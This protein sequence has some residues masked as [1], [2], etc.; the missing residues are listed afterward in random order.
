M[1]F[2]RSAVLRQIRALAYKNVLVTVIRRPAGFLFSTY[3]FPI[4]I[5]WFLIALPSLLSSSV[6]NGVSSPAAVKS[7]AE[8]VQNRLIIVQPDDLGPDVSRVI[9]TFT[10]SIPR[11]KVV[12]TSTESDLES[13]CATDLTGR[14]E[15]HGAVIFVDSPL[16][17]NKE[18]DGSSGKAWKYTIRAD[19]AL[20]DRSFDATSHHGAQEDV[21]LPLQVAIDRAITN[22]TSQPEVFRFTEETQAEATKADLQNRVESVSQVYAFALF[23]AYYLTIYRLT[24]FVT[25]ERES[26]MSQLLDAMGGPMSPISRVLSWLLVVD[27]LSIPCFIILGAIYSHMLFPTSSIGVVILWQVLLGLAVNSSTVFAASFFSSSRTSAIYVMGVFLLLSIITNSYANNLD[28]KPQFGGALFLS[29]FFPSSGH[30]F[31][32]QQLSFWELLGTAVDLNSLPP[33]D[34]G[35]GLEYG[36]NPSMLLGFLGLQIIVYPCATILVEILMHGIS[37]RKRTFPTEVASGPQHPFE[38]TDLHKKFYPGLMKRIFCCGRKGVVKALDG[39]S[40]QGKQG[41]ITCLLGPNGSGKT[42][43]LHMLSGFLTPSSGSINLGVQ[44]SQMGVCPQRD[45]FWEQLSVMEHIKIWS[46][47]KSAR[48]LPSKELDDLAE[49]CDLGWKR[50][51]KASTLSG[52]QKRKLQLACMF[53]GDSRLCLIDECTSGLDPLS[54]QAVWKILLQQRSRRTIVLTTHF[55]DEV[56]ILADDIVIMSK[57]KIKCQGPSAELT[58]RYGNGYTV[59]APVSVPRAPADGIPYSIYQD[60]VLYK[61]ADSYS[62]AK[63]CSALSAAGAV[64]LSVS[65]PSIEDVF[66]RVVDDV[67]GDLRQT[68]DTTGD[69]EFEMTPATRIGFGKQVLVIIGKRFTILKHFWWPYFYALVITLVVTPQLQGMLMDYKQ[70]PCQLVKTPMGPAETLSLSWDESC[71]TSGCDR[72]TLGPSAANSTLFDLVRAGNQAFASIGADAATAF[73]VVQDDRSAFIDYIKNNVDE[74]LGGLFLPSD[75]SRPL[76]GYRQRVGSS[77]AG[78]LANLWSQMVSGVDIIMSRGT[79]GT[80]A[81][82]EGSTIGMIYVMFFTFV[83]AIYPAVF[84][85]YPAMERSRKVRALEYANGVR[86]GPIWVAYGLF[87]LMWVMLISAGVTLFLA[88]R[89]LNGS[90]GIMY[91]VLALYGLT[92]VFTGYIVS[93]FTNGPLKTFITTFALSVVFYAISILALAVSSPSRL[94]PKTP[95][96]ANNC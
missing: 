71:A 55:L 66:M 15:C 74:N 16:T 32:V 62:A 5:L 72:L 49:S 76:I 17:P 88:S 19:P 26:G 64:G 47:I 70:P 51:S 69:S 8:T 67:D 38:V 94:H 83:Q 37:N 52:G 63:L 89:N 13:L 57:G 75:D 25:G 29:L 10:E 3:V 95:R 59:A 41:Q 20:D 68:I 53:V 44:W 35:F 24:R 86:R 50:E 27:V 11:D 12:F 7:L 31:F 1:L 45:T 36:V 56:E 91:C 54:R 23:A 46:Q 39:V 34:P 78:V 87:D 2:D 6:R 4:A 96:K 80:T 42:T 82:P 77:T 18:G 92:G 90:L 79:F 21:Y 33:S 65:S 22:S 60:Q 14:S 30:I 73:T 84:S 93:H 28:P 43:T 81:R 9:E 85:L 48:P 58:A 40:F 61:T